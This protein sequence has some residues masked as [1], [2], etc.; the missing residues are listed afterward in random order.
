MDIL[1]MVQDVTDATS[2]QNRVPWDAA[3]W[4]FFY[5]PV[6]GLFSAP[7]PGLTSVKPL[8]H[9]VTMMFSYHASR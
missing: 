4:H 3:G 6:F 9:S 7:V 2:E 8:R 1:I 5:G